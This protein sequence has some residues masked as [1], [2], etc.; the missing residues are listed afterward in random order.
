MLS[1]SLTAKYSTLT[2]NKALGAGGL[3]G[4]G[5]AGAAYS[6]EV[7]VRG[8]T[9]DHNQADVVA[10]LYVGYADSSSYG[11]ILQ[12]TI[13]SNTSNLAF[14]AV[15]AKATL[16]VANS[17]IA[18]NTSGSIGGP[19]LGI[20]SG[21]S[22]TVDS[23]IVADN[24]PLDLDGGGAIGGANNLIK[25]PGT[26]VTLPFGTFTLDP[27]LGPLQLNGGH[28]RTHA[29]TPGSPAIDQ[30]ADDAKLATDQ[31]GPTYRRVVGGKADIGAYE[32]DADHVFGDGFD[33]GPPLS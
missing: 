26:N 12:S 32:L 8:C 5:L 15:L 20:S 16:G 11:T 7:F 17:T 2:G 1:R 28:T 30:G 21:V 27:Q 18:F 10:A 23:T 33:P 14:G 9:L 6:F 22:A 4:V 25:L 13:S 24:S 3:T 31:R 29:L 19:A